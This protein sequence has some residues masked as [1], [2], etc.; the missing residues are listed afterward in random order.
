ME[1]P[2]GDDITVIVS[3][4]LHGYSRL[5]EQD[6]FGTHRA[7]MACWRNQLVPIVD[8]HRGDIVK[9]TGDGALIRFSGALDAVEA[10]ICFQREVT[11]S[12]TCFPESRRLVFRVGIHLAPTIQEDGDVFGHGV[13]LAVRLQEAAE[14]GSILLSDAVK[15]QLNSK[16]SASLKALGRVTLK[17]IEERVRAHSWWEREGRTA[18]DRPRAMPLVAALLLGLVLPTAALD[19]IDPYNGIE[20][21]AEPANPV[22]VALPPASALRADAIEMMP[23][24]PSAGDGWIQPYRGLSAGPLG[25]E[26]KPTMAAAERSVESRSEIAEDAYWQALALYG[27]HTPEAFAQAAGELDQ[28]LMLQADYPA[29]HA[30]MSAVF[31]GGLQNRWQLGRGL[32]RA[33][34]LNRARFHLAA[35][36]EPE[37]LAHMVASEMLTASGRHDLAIEEAERAIALAP[38]R[39]VGHYAKGQALLFAGNATAAERAIRAAIRIDPDASRYLFG[40]ALAQFSRDRFLEAKRTLARVTRRNDADDWPHLLLAATNGFLGQGEEARVAMGRFDRLSVPRRGW[41]ASQIP[42]VHDWPFRDRRDR[43]RLHKGM[44]LAGVPEFER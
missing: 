40:L 20:N 27:R 1:Q 28:A 4:D 42:Y 31:W 26:I 32:T 10:M 13:N 35:V 8:G 16:R 9:S 41:F 17:N 7:L 29:A 36:T 3:L 39:A 15:R 5:T 14:P 2:S 21:A 23:A 44:V 24:L 43:E 25:S 37:P 22:T 19:E 30:L 18:V 6:E 11:R 12:E 38:E 34:M 33:D